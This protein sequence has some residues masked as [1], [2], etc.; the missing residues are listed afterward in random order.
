ME[1]RCKACHENLREFG[2]YDQ[3]NRLICQ[4]CNSLQEEIEVNED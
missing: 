3:E 1:Y 4:N 2:M